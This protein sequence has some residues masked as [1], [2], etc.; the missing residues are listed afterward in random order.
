M[1]EIY[2]PDC[3]A[4]RHFL[5]IGLI[6]ACS[7]SMTFDAELQPTHDFFTAGRAPPWL[8]LE[9]MKEIINNKTE[10]KKNKP[11]INE[12]EKWKTHK[13]KTVTNKTLSEVVQLNIL[14]T[15]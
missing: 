7:T 13:Q 1:R 9:Y 8:S 10:Q 14:H 6:H 4:A 2:L 11:K 5:F 15:N 3:H 12:T